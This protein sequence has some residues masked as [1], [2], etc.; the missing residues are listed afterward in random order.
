[1]VTS[2]LVQPPE[3][4][5]TPAREFWFIGLPVVAGVSALFM[6]LLSGLWAGSEDSQT[7][8]N[9]TQQNHLLIATTGVLSICLIILAVHNR[10]TMK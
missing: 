10:R 5:V 7:I 2:S 3:S 8:A 6:I 1:M 4:S 9:L